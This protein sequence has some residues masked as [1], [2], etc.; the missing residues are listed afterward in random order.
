[1]EHGSGGSGGLIRPIRLIRSLSKLPI[2]K[3][4]SSL[5]KS[6]RA[7][8]PIDKASR[9]SIMMVPQEQSIRA[10]AGSQVDFQASEFS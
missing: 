3:V 10:A 5:V 9:I 8:A 2:L 6:K 4:S 7:S 1:M